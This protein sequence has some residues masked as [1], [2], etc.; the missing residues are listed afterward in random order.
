MPIPIYE[1]YRINEEKE[2]D[3]SGFEIIDLY[4]GLCRSYQEG[5]GAKT[6]HFM[7]IAADLCHGLQ[8]GDSC[9]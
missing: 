7:I 8:H 5:Y 1:Y 4:V 3:F 9:S 2:N 6:I